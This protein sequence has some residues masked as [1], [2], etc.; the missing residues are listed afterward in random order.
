MRILPKLSLEQG[1]TATAS[2]L[3]STQWA[4][5]GLLHIVQL[6]LDSPLQFTEFLS[7][8]MSLTQLNQDR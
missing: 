3:R 2:E 5:M 4:G 1:P 8:P 7:I 6:S